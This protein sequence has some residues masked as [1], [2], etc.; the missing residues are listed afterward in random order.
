MRKTKIVCTIGPACWSEEMLKKMMLGGMNVARFNFSH[1]TQPDHKEKIDRVKKIRKKLGIPVAVLLDTRGPEIRTGKLENGS[2]ELTEGRQI[3]LTTEETEGNA[4]RVSVTYRNLPRNLKKG[5]TLM[6][7]DGKI[8]LAVREIGETDIL[9][10]IVN[11]GILKDSK[12]VNTP[13]ITIDMPYIDEKDKSDI[14]FGAEND[15]DYIAL[16]FVRT[17]QDI[18][19]VRRLLNSHGYYNIELLAKIENTEGVK[20]ITDII[21]VSDGI[22]IARGDMAVEIPFEELPHLQKTIITSC[23]SAGKKV[24]TATEMLDSMIRH[25]RPTR[26][27]ITDVA[28][29]IYDGTSAIMLSGETAIGAYP[30]RSLETMS[31]IAEKTEANIDYKTYGEN[32]G[33]LKRLEINI[34]NAI[35][36]ATCRAAYDLNAAAIVAVTLRGS[37]A[38]MISRFRPGAP[39]IAVTPDEKSYMKLALA[40]GVTPIMNEY[41]ENENDLFND[42]ASRILET[43]LV[44]EG[45]VIVM[46]GSTQRSSGSTN[47][48]Q[49]HIVGDIL[50]KG[51]GAGLEDV[52]GRVYVVKESE[53]DFSGFSPGD[54]IAAARTTTD[55]L[56]IMRQCAGVITEEN[57]EDSG[58]V[59]A[60]Y[61]L[62]IPVISN[63]NGATAMLRTGVRIKLDAQKGYVYNTDTNHDV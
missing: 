26:A 38:R 52:S 10:D 34:S 2:A 23:Y 4:G 61:A 15:V 32:I 31:K 51:K 5:N 14:L 17:P 29:A 39:I 46:T 48:L 44:K 41:V 28:N 9:C 19:D 40:W 56:Q 25:P 58:I 36:D 62:D 11:G 24:I 1:G 7:D 12:S 54:I 20:N 35:S 53:K 63:A 45:D 27:E 33:S 37:S 50:L 43:G 47:T 59:A 13:G 42:V 6:V 18:K 16:S 21:N 57:E 22:M 55:V 3:V 30:L 49:V 8:E 60:A